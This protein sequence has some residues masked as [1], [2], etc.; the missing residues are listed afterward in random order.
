MNYVT[1]ESLG[2]GDELVIEVDS[3]VG[4]LAKIN[5]SATNLVVG[6]VRVPP[7]V[8]GTDRLIAEIYPEVYT[9]IVA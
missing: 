6:R 9:H 4:K 7:T 2:I 5:S 8:D 3:S 1:G